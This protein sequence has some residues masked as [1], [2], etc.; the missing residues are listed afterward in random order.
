M[1]IH[2]YNTYRFKNK[3]PIIDVLRTIVKDEGLSYA[4][5]CR[6]GNMSP[7]PPYNWFHGK[8]KRPQHA[9]IKAFVRACSVNG[10][11]YDYE[12]TKN[13]KS[14]KRHGKEE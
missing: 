12:V 9:S 13:G 11:K 1:P 8:T 10:T 6:E 14:I 4:Q 2:I 7:T 3:D 5:I